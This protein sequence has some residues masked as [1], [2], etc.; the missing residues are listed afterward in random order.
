MVILPFFCSCHKTEVEKRKTDFQKGF[1]D[2]E[3]QIKSEK[4]IKLSRIADS[5]SYVF[6][7]TKDECLLSNTNSIIHIDSQDIFIYSDNNIYRFSN[8]G[9]FLNKI[10]NRGMGPEE[11][12]SY[13]YSDVD[14]DNKLLLLLSQNNALYFYNYEG[15]FI[16]KI[17]LDGEI[18]AIKCFG[19]KSFTC[20]KSNYSD[21][22][23][24]TIAQYDYEGKLLNQ[25]I[26]EKDKSNFERSLYTS[27]IMYHYNNT[28][29]YKSL[30]NDTLYQYCSDK[31]SKNLIL[32][33][34][35]YSPKREYIEDVNKK[36]K[37][38]MQYIQIV[39]I[40]E[41][42][43]YLF[44]LAIKGK[45]IRSLIIDKTTGDLVFN[46]DIDNPK[47]GGGIANDINGKGYFY[48]MIFF[49]R[50][51]LAQIIYP[52]NIQMNDVDENSNPVIQI[53]HLKDK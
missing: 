25:S 12:S 9:L 26:I 28:I 50:N 33:L 6:L 51:K 29:K 2:I 27:S 1:I 42:Q 8:S 43:Q 24:S 16:K 5:I 45:K 20:E 10:G 30:Y 17:K 52:N 35:K 49:D 38:L 18:K 15:M 44:V 32:S 21:G 37:L 40:I 14:S 11:Y 39:H 22:Y 46:K 3:G 7:E 48:P 13:K 53:I 23:C 36:E 19:N 4:R 31:I 34:G 41:S 47:K